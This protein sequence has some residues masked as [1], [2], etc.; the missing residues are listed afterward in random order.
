MNNV[1]GNG[2]EADHDFILRIRQVIGE[3]EP[4]N[5]NEPVNVPVI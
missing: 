3:T 2:G 4:V 5:V 1:V